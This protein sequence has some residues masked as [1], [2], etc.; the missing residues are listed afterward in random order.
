[1]HHTPLPSRLAV[2]ARALTAPAI[3]LTV[4]IASASWS[5]AQDDAKPLAERGYAIGDI[6]LGDDSAKLTM[7]EYVS[8]TCPHCASFHA[9][10]FPRLKADYID[11][12]KI[13]FIAR[14]VYFDGEGL[15]AARI[16]RCAGPESYY[17]LYDTILA[18][19]EKWIRESDIGRA[20]YRTA[21]RAGMP[22]SRI[23][24]CVDDEEF[25][26]SLVETYKTQSAADGV[27][28]TPTFFIGDERVQGAR[29]YEEFVEVIEA[30]LADL[31]EGTGNPH[32]ESSSAFDRV[33][34]TIKG[35]F[36]G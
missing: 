36:G 27:D 3:A 4:V 15:L 12:G 8:F 17:E 16:A 19:Q 31:G 9:D 24:T 22:A 23:K 30:Q 1:M 10:S 28:S 6:V 5:L 32:S 14:E 11:T 25:A 35:I 26:L 29:P 7:I 2:A 20:L 18:D 13:R 34:S 33:I 21:V